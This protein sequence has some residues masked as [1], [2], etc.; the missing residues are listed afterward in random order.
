VHIGRCMYVQGYIGND[1]EQDV[2]TSSK[3]LARIIRM[4]N[5]VCN[6]SGCTCA[7]LQPSLIHCRAPLNI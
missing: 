7:M 2:A 3:M 5:V 4:C 6:A 1:T